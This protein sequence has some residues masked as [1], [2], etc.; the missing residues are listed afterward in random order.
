MRECST[1][2]IIKAAEICSDHDPS[3]G[4]GGCPFIDECNDE[5]TEFD[6]YQIALNRLKLI[7]NENELLKKKISETDNSLQSKLINELHTR[8]AQLNDDLDKDARI[9]ELEKQLRDIYTAEQAQKD[10]LRYSDITDHKG[11]LYLQIAD[12]EKLKEWAKFHPD[13]PKMTNLDKFKEVFGRETWGVCFKQKPI[14][15]IH[16]KDNVG[17]D[18]CEYGVS[19]EYKQPDNK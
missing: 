13:K 16:P 2:D 18:A 12:L 7:R 1:E 11:K 5:D 6:I 10:F 15:C 8:N 17:C 14:A 9:A 19:G 4:C 3:R